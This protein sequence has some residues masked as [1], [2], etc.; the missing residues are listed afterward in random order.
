MTIHTYRAKAKNHK[1]S[2]RLPVRVSCRVVLPESVDHVAIE[3]LQHDVANMDSPPIPPCIRR[4][5]AHKGYVEIPGKTR[6]EARA[7][8]NA[9]QEYAH[10]PGLPL[11]HA[12]MVSML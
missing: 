1:K 4:E 7:L 11:D 10:H 5:L 8:R 2:S 12:I 6:G 9:S 3:V